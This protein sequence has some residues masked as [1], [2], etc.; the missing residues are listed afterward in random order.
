MMT[1]IRRKY[2]Y[3]IRRLIIVVIVVCWISYDLSIQ[4]PQRKQ[5][6]QQSSSPRVAAGVVLA[7][8][9]EPEPSP[10]QQSSSSSSTTTRRLDT[11]RLAPFDKDIREDCVSIQLHCTSDV[12]AHVFLQCPATCTALLHEEGMKGTVPPGTEDYL[13]EVGMLRTTTPRQDDPQQQQQ[14]RQSRSIDAE[15][16]EG[17][18]LVL[19]VVPLLP[20]M[21]VYYYELMEHLHTIFCKKG[22]EFVVLP[23]DV[24]LGIHIQERG[25]SSTTAG[26]KDKNNHKQGVVVLEEQPISAVEKHVWMKHLT[27]VTPRS[28]AALR[29]DDDDDDSDDDDDDNEN[30]NSSG[31]N[32][33]NPKTKVQQ[34]PLHT[35]RVTFYIVSADGHFVERVISPT[36]AELRKK[37]STYIKTVDYEL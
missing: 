9:P 3:Y 6:Q 22:T 17:S 14:R 26:G 36:L 5:Q 11:S 33:N 15:R 37:V 19:A 25:G 4:K 32:K 31:N 21:A 8:D 10:Q 16:F 20:G 23:I 24:E 29:D 30:D 7:T 1:M 35:D 27:S 34:T 12:F 28:G 2:Y 18:V 13:Y